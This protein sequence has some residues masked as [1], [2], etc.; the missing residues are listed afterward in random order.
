MRRDM[1][2]NAGQDYV[3]DAR[4]PQRVREQDERTVAEPGGRAPRRIPCR[5]R[6]ELPDRTGEAT[7]VFS[8]NRRNHEIDPEAHIERGRVRGKDGK[9]RVYQF[10]WWEA[11]DNE[12]WRAH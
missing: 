7:M 5:A 12:V 2:M 3:G 10:E 8:C 4:L 9:V 11:G 1:E 6:I